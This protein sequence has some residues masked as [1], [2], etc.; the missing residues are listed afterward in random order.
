VYIIGWKSGGAMVCTSFKLPGSYDAINGPP[1]VVRDAPGGEDWFVWWKRA[2]LSATH[3]H[4]ALLPPG[5]ATREDWVNAAGGLAPDPQAAQCEHMAAWNSGADALPAAQP[6]G[7]VTRMLDLEFSELHPVHGADTPGFVRLMG[8]STHSCN[9]V[10]RSLCLVDVEFDTAL[11][12]FRKEPLS[13]AKYRAVDYNCAGKYVEGRTRDD[14][15]RYR[16]YVGAPYVIAHARRPS[17]VWMRRGAGNGDGYEDSA[18]VLHY[19]V[20]KTRDETAT[21]LGELHLTGFPES[22]EPAFITNTT[23]VNPVFVSVVAGSDGFRLLAQAAVPR[24]KESRAVAL[25]CFPH[26]D[27]S[28]LQRPP[29][30]VPDRRDPSRSYIVFSRVRIGEM[31]NPGPLPAAALELVVATLA[32]GACSGVT[33]TSFAHY[34]DGFAAPDEVTATASA[35]NRASDAREAIGRFAARVRGGQTVL[36][37]VTGDG[38][39][40]LV[41]VAKVPQT[42]Q[43]VRLR[44]ALLVGRTDSTGLTFH[45]I[46]GS[47][48]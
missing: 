1:M 2:K 13:P 4:F 18:T 7:F 48:P 28:W 6:L 30:L 16:N 11:R 32:N 22:R 17:L 33:E 45:E 34:F 27:N 21:D 23:T 24:G 29:A 41:Q 8:L 37:D 25:D 46:P 3:G 40:D 43:T 9:K 42:S 15:D 19:T 14:C 5:R 38:I 39:P 31:A 47:R 20:G 26:A 35:N 36:A 44:S 12:Q 10:D